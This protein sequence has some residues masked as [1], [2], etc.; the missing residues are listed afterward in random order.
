MTTLEDMAAACERELEEAN[1]EG[2]WRAMA[3]P[4]AAAAGQ[5]VYV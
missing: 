4:A 1:Q 2:G 3:T 5:P